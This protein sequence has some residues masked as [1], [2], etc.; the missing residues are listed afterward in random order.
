MKLSQGV[1]WG[2]HCCIVL[3]QAT[4]PVPA[5]RLALFHGVSQTY[6][7]KHLQALARAGLVRSTQG[8][9]GGYE[10]VRAPEDITLLDVVRAIDGDEPAFRCTEIRQ[11]GPL[12]TPPEECVRP[13]AVARAMW[14]AEDAWRASLAAVTIADLTGHVQHDTD[15]AA[16]PRLRDWLTTA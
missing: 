4:A 2:L 15:G 16:M 14:A 7:A 3:G 9:V 5:A 12:G 1:E 10:L 6:L 13:C 11:R 8:Q